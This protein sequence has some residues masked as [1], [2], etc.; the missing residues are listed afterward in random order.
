MD[1]DVLSPMIEGLNK[2]S[3]GVYLSLL[4]NSIT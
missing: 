4:P 3:Q 2:I 1:N